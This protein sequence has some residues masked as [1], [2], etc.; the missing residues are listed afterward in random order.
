LHHLKS[1]LHHPR[2]EI[3]AILPH[4]HTPTANWQT[5]CAGALGRNSP[6][7]A[8]REKEKSFAGAKIGDW[9]SGGRV[10]VAVATEPPITLV[11]TRWSHEDAQNPMGEFCAPSQIHEGNNEEA[12]ILLFR[13][14]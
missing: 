14:T 10:E 4:R 6:H 12:D 1:I 8:P 3:Q 9:Q 2:G 11:G 7:F 13:T 5:T